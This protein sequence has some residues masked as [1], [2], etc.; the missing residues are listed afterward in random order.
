[1]I[2]AGVNKYKQ[3]ELWNRHSG[4]PINSGKLKMQMMSNFITNDRVTYETRSLK[5]LLQV[6]ALEFRNV[7]PDV[8]LTT[9]IFEILQA[10]INF[11]RPSV[12]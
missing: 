3:A 8:A 1:M 10:V 6:T 7:L 11:R 5:Q 2:T 9:I 12:T 4:L